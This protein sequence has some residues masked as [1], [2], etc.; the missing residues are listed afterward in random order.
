[1]N[2]AQSI[3]ALLDK[4]DRVIIPGLGILENK[5]YPASLNKQRK[6]LLPPETRTT[7][8]AKLDAVD[9][10]LINYLADTENISREESKNA[11]EAYVK[12]LR[13]KLKLAHKAKIEKVGYLIIRDKQLHFKPDVVNDLPTLEAEPIKE[14]ARP[15]AVP[16]PAKVADTKPARP[17]EA[18]KKEKSVS[19]VSYLAM[20]LILLL[21][22][23]AILLY[24]VINPS[25]TP[26]FKSQYSGHIPLTEYPAQEIKVREVSPVINEDIKTPKPSQDQE[27][28]E[29]EEAPAQAIA[30]EVEP[31]PVQP[32]V[33]E[34]EIPEEKIVPTP[35]TG[36]YHIIVASLEYKTM[37]EVFATKLIDYG[38]PEATIIGPA[39]NGNYRV[40]LDNFNEK[41]QAM[42]H[43]M[44][45]RKL[46]DTKAWL[47]KY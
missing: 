28:K 36:K 35:R 9:E 24:V 22:M 21:I 43:L 33:E 41:T 1:M 14:Q 38:Y 44:Y 31:E 15:Q 39:R 7:F 47:L 40:S 4:E 6:R 27:I 13:S 8:L 5:Y 25:N 10:L 11:V 16:V 2:I 37:A 30:E 26:F 18:E 46:I 17:K 23:L 42:L 34:L 19:F 32:P 12:T 29:T 3:R 45:A 20:P